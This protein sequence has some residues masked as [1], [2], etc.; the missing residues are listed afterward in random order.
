MERK[1]FVT[2]ISL[3]KI[4]REIFEP[5]PTQIAIAMSGGI[6]STALLISAIEAGK[7]PTVLSFTFDGHYS[8]DFLT[9]KKVADHF[10]VD[11][12]PVYLPTDQAEILA[13]IRLLTKSYNLKKKAR[14]ECAFPFLYL[15]KKLQALKIAT[16]AT[17]LCADGHFGLSKK[18]MI[19]HRYPQEKFDAFRCDYFSNPDAGGRKGI[20]Q[21]CKN[22]NIKIV[23]PY[24]DT[25]VFQLFIGRSWDELNKPRQKEAIRS[26]YPELDQFKI[27]RHSNLQLGD[28]LIAERLGA[29]AMSAIPN[30]RS[31]IAAY[32]RIRA[33]R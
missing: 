6:D 21:I 27:L 10:N 8:T 32:N 13:S 1:I 7:R 22:A 17:G 11:F 9:A 24:Y 19:H 12:C 4:I 16:L 28:S 18:A 26:E 20:T 25:K 29:A 33:A 14:I 23:N 5:L 30:T 31:A 2:N 3:R 15:S